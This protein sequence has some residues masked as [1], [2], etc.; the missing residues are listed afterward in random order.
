VDADEI[1]VLRNGEV[2]ERGNHA[3][4]LAQGGLYAQMWATQAA[5]QELEPAE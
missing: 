3:V 4:L 5:E 2:A 1:I